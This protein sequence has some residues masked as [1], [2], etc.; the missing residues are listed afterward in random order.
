MLHSIAASLDAHRQT[1]ID[2]CSEETALTPEELA[3]EFAR[4]TGTLRMFANLLREGSWVRAS[5]DTRTSEPGAPAAD[6]SPP[7]LS[8]PIIGPNHDVRKH[9]IPLGPVAVFGSSNF[10]LAYGVCGGDTASALAAGCPV[11]VKEHPAHPRTGRLIAEVAK[12]GIKRTEA[13]SSCIQIP[14]AW[15]QYLRNEDPTDHSIAASLVAH[16]R[17]AAV[18]FTGSLRGGLAV[19]QVAAARPFPIP[20]YAEM[21]SLN[22]IVVLRHAMSS[23]PEQIADELTNS[24]LARNGQQCTAPG[25]IIIAG[26]DNADWMYRALDERIQRVPARRMLSPWIAHEYRQRIAEVVKSGVIEHQCVQVVPSNAELD[27][28]PA[29]ILY[30]QAVKLENPEAMPAWKEIFGPAAILVGAGMN[31]NAMLFRNGALTTTIIGDPEDFQDS[32]MDCV[33]DAFI[34]RGVEIMELLRERCGRLAFNSPPTGVRVCTS[35]VHGG[36]FP[37]TNAP[38]T[39]AVGP[40]AIERWCRPVCYQNCPDAFLPPELQDANPLGILRTVNGVP[41]RDPVTR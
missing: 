16:R 18:G 31:A 36:P 4:M 11:I 10:P 14:S 34:G 19:A 25:M 2:T 1:I 20:V 17:V 35:M 39:T 3:P 32:P 26:Y 23:R 30:T 9:L 5:I 8:D 27:V 40:L 41:T 6:R 22:V 15:I 38:H 29:T 12:E 24:L 33:D 13:P 28:V 21:G 37:A 7:A